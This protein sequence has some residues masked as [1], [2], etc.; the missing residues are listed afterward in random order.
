MN[1]FQ[2]KVALVTGGTSGIGRLGL[3][4]HYTKLISTITVIRPNSKSRRRSSIVIGELAE[5]MA[6]TS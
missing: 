5:M 1:E 2:G 6:L 3:E 4:Q